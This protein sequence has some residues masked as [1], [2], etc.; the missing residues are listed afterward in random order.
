MSYLYFLLIIIFISSII[1]VFYTTNKNN[2]QYP[3]T[4]PP[5]NDEPIFQ[6]TF[7]PTYIPT[8]EPTYVPT[9]LPTYEPTYIPTYEPTIPPP[10]YITDGIYK[11]NTD[12]VNITCRTIGNVFDCSRVPGPGWP[13]GRILFNISDN[14]LFIQTGN[15]IGTW[16]NNLKVIKWN[17]NTTWTK[18]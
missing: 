5:F 16:N 9:Y 17:N 15:L 4:L 12:N 8:Y 13:N 2:S 14:R 6:P 10:N 7:Q 1:A 3:I 18:N 11:S